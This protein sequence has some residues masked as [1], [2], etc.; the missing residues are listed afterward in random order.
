MKIPACPA[1]YWETVEDADS[2]Y[3]KNQRQWIEKN[4]KEQFG[5]R[6]DIHKN[7]AF[8][9]LEDEDF[10]GKLH[11]KD[12]QLPEVILLLGGMIRE[13]VKAGRWKRERNET[14]RI[15]REAF[16]SGTE[17]LWKVNYDPELYSVYSGRGQ[18]AEP[19]GSFWFQR[20]E[21]GVLFFRGGT[22]GRVYR[23]S[24]SGI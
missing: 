9:V 7:A 2:L 18:D 23:L 1:M 5:G 20:P 4:M 14:I 13:N 8:W 17:R 24:F 15:S 10:Y 19:S 21:D 11:P 16:A 22:A 12:A 6:L 3:L